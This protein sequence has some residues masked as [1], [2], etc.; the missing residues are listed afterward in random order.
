MVSTVFDSSLLLHAHTFK[1]SRH[2]EILPDRYVALAH[3]STV[4]FWWKVGG[5]ELTNQGPQEGER[6]KM[7]RKRKNKAVESEQV[8]EDPCVVYCRLEENRLASVHSKIIGELQSQKH[9]S[10]GQNQEVCKE[11][12]RK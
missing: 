2:C 5:L 1:T 10:S 11:N 7:M 8:G 12:T 6:M 9:K 3:H 4:G